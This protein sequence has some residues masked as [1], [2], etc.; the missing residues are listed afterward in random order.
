MYMCMCVALIVFTN[1]N[2][3]Y[4]DKNYNTQMYHE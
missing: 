3:L 4:I 1:F 2:L